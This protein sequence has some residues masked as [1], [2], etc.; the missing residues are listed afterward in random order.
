M[1]LL[2]VVFDNDGESTAANAVKAVLLPVWRRFGIA[3][4]PPLIV[5]TPES[6]FSGLNQLGYDFEGV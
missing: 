6:R 2:L 1:R 5:R 3:N 4:P